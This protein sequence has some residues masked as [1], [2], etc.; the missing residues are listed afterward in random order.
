MAQTATD[1]G[2]R[3][4]SSGG[5]GSVVY[6]YVAKRNIAIRII[7]IADTTADTG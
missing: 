7:S 6:R 4:P 3:W 1:A 5:H 2:T